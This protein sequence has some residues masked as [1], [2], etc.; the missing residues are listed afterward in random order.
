[1]QGGTRKDGVV[2]VLSL[3]AS[4]YLAFLVLDSFVFRLEWLWLQGVRERLT[5]PLVLA[6]AVIFVFSVAR[7]LAN[8]RSVH[9][10]RVGSVLILLALNCLIW[11]L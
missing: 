3:L 9:A 6:V 5:I 4:A 1:M 8:R 7:L 11:G 2:R 10:R